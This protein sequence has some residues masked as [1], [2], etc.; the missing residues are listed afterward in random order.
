M[1]V[2]TPFADESG[3]DLPKVT[4][5]TSGSAGVCPQACLD[6]VQM[7][8]VACWDSQDFPQQLLILCSWCRHPARL[9]GGSSEGGRQGLPAGPRD[10]DLAWAASGGDSGCH[11]WAGIG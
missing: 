6:A 8:R 10:A 7:R 5:P 1:P 11:A 2:F 9:S 3:N 4:E